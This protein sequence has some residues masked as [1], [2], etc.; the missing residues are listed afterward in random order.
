MVDILTTEKRSALMGKI[1]RAHTTPEVVIRKGLHKAG[2]R[3]RVDCRNLPGAPDI[4]LP[5]HRAAIFVHGC[6]WHGHDCHLFRVPRTR[7]DFW[8]AKIAGNRERDER[9]LARL[10]REG[11]RV[12]VVWECSLRGPGRADT[13][14]LVDKITEWILTGGKFKAIRGKK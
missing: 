1:R 6:F 11:W 10:R 2:F 14:K 3:Y 7:T 13:R 5:K 9:T 12:L 8:A 4:V